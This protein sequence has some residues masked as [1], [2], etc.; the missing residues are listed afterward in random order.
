MPFF[1]EG[2][3]PQPRTP[4]ADCY[5]YTF[6]VD[7]ASGRTTPC[8][9]QGQRAEYTYESTVAASPNEDKFAVGVLSPIHS[10]G[11]AV[12]VLAGGPVYVGHDVVVGIVNFTNNDGDVVSLPVA[13]DVDDADDGDWIVARATRGTHTTAADTDINRPSLALLF[14]SIPQQFKGGAQARTQLTFPVNLANIAA[15]GDVITD[16]LAGYAYTIIDHEFV[17]NVPATTAGAA[18]SLSLEINATAVTGGAV[19]LTSANAT[20]QGKVIAGTAITGNNVA[21]A[22]DTLTVRATVTTAFTEGSGTIVITI[23]QTPTA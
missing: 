5:A 12:P 14:Y 2:D 17:V 9:A 22:N 10:G 15:T 1:H 13:I 19:A 21:D 23:E 16:Y 3:N 11:T 7:L 4:H 20:P 18:I 6:G 8:T